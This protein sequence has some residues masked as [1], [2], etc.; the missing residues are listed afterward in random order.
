MVDLLVDRME[1][2]FFF[3]NVGFDIF[4]FWMIC[5]WKICGG[6]VNFKCWGLVF[7]CFSSRV[8]YIELL[9]FM[10]S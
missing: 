4:G 6:V 1:V 8:I 3:M 5:F 9:E 10:G 7:I 2:I